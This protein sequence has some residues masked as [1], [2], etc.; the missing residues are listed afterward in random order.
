MKYTI[1]TVA[2]MTGLSQYTIRAWERRHHTSGPTRTETN[3]RLYDESDVSRLQLLKQAVDSGH[4]IGQAAQLSNDELRGL[5]VRTKEASSPATDAGEGQTSEFIINVCITA[6]ESLDEEALRECLLRGATSLGAQVFIE[7]V[8][9]PLISL[10]EHR[11]IEKTISIAQEHMVSAVLRTN[12]ERLRTSIPVSAK[13]ARI[14]ITTPKGQIHELGAL[15]ISVIACLESWH[16]TYLGPNLPA[17]EIARAALQSG[18][19]AIALSLVY[20]VNDP[21]VPVELARLRDLVGDSFPILV[22]GRATSDYSSA[23]EESSLV[24]CS[25][26]SEFRQALARFQTG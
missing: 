17:D 12:L 25:E 7:K 26:I 8:V 4:S 2:T 18:S 5:F 14:I 23:I 1:R 3:R 10:V 20:P 21:Q 22:G 15:I 9:I 24:N 13:A 16:V 11:W 19:K 6:I